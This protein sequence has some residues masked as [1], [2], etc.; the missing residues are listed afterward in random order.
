MIQGFVRDSAGNPISDALVVV[1][2]NDGSYVRRSTSDIKGVYR[3]GLLPPG[4]YNLTAQRIGF[5][6]FGARD[7]V[8]AANSVRAYNVTL[9]HRAVDLAEVVVKAD[10]PI[11]E[12]KSA[13]LGATRVTSE[14]IAKLPV[15]A[16]VE[17]LVAM[18]PGARGS[19]LW[20]AAGTAANNYQ[21][22]G[23]SIIN[24]GIGGAFVQPSVRWI[25]SLEVKG[26]GADAQEGNFQGGLVNVITK[27]GSNTRH[28]SV[29]FNLEDQSLNGTNL[30]PTTLVP[31]IAGRRQFIGQVSGPIVR[32]RLFYY[33][34]GELLAGN[35]RSLDHLNTDTSSYAPFTQMRTDAKAFGKLTFS[36]ND[37]DL[38]NL[39]GTYYNRLVDH[40]GFSG[41]E[42]AEATT[43]FRAPT[44]LLNASWQRVLST[45]T[46][47]E[48][49]LL[50]FDGREADVPVAGPNVPG[51]Y[52]YQLTTTRS[53]QNAPFT[54]EKHAR[55]MGGS[56]A[57][58]HYTTISGAS[59]HVRVGAEYSSA[60][61]TDQ[62]T[63]NGGMTW[64]PR[65][66]YLDGS[67]KTFDP[68]DAL[69]WNTQTPT[70]WGGEVDLATHT[71]NAAA[72]VQ[73]E[74]KKGNLSLFPGVRI[75]SWRGDLDPTVRGVT[76][77]TNV[78]SD[79]GLDP[80]LGVTLFLPD[81][82]TPT[83]LAAHL[84]RYHQS[85]F[86]ELFDRAQGANAYTDQEVWEYSGPAFSNPNRIITRAERDALASQGKFRQ[87]EN[88]VLSQSGPVRN[89]HQPYVDQLVAGFDVR[90]NSHWRAEMLFV[91]RDNHDM[92]ALVD[93]NIAT[94]Y[95]KWD[96]VS[97][98]DRRGNLVLDS[99]GKPLLLRSF[100]A[101]NDAIVA[102]IRAALANPGGGVVLPPG[103]TLKDTTLR[104]TPDYAVTNPPEAKRQFRQWQIT[105]DTDFPAWS[106]TV[107]FAFSGLNGNVST[108]LGGYDQV[109]IGGFEAIQGR[110][111]GPF[112][113]PNEA[114]NFEG[115][116][117]NAS[118]LTIKERLLFDLPF[119][120]RGGVIGE[121]ISGD[122]LT[123][124]FIV[125]PAAFVYKVGNTEL[126]PLLTQGVSR[127]RFYTKQQGSLRY[128]GRTTVD[129]HLERAFVTASGSLTL[130]V[131]GFNVFGARNPTLFNTALSSDADP[132]SLTKFGT[133]LARQAPRQLRVGA[134]LNW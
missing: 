88:V 61:W 112:V 11:A 51:I 120:F 130:L 46:T 56:F 90:P 109:S 80:R 28:A 110:G 79:I 119:D 117:D 108:D 121:Y 127:Q 92:V 128:S 1:A 15:G 107:S 98:Y 118:F 131:D 18:A 49:K 123:P 64:R 91:G 2:R 48:A 53:Y 20:G 72:Y 4:R 35:Y 7:I 99:D 42:T 37:R 60:T 41:R 69:T 115:G 47:I 93:G 122:Q 17:R 73:D 39:T 24:P 116:L 14:A 23:V 101:P 76:T 95:R 94:N 113:R 31:E 81:P 44:T 65:Y 38:L 126:W 59:H 106:N 9:R 6:P 71:L 10:A 21:L 12:Q 100:Y 50:G 3:V 32:D 125:V 134:A 57:V 82:D 30:T 124:S 22:D 104:F 74:I 129:V 62:R 68:V 87:I 5:L 27:T 86:G 103:V 19:N 114:I 133:P 78:L 43:N 75:G 77:R 85:A 67:D 13:E 25:E 89:Y 16:D 58:D 66:N 52:T 70:T 111:P 84:G 96:Y 36:P 105:V 29:E 102:T 97:V 8:V 40:A 54:I 83:R 55:S 132:N 34:G 63:R 33:L 45:A 26:L